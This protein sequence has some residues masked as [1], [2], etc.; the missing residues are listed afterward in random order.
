M[1]RNG[2]RLIRAALLAVVVAVF[3]H[4]RAD[5]DLWGHVRFGQDTVAA[6]AV[7]TV[8]RYSFASD[9]PWINHEWLAEALMY[10]AYAAAAGPGLILLKVSVLLLM[11]WAAASPWPKE[12][13]PKYRDLMV[14]LVV[15]GTLPQANHIRPQLFS[16]ILFA[17]L[18]KILVRGADTA[19]EQI[20]RGVAVTLLMV[21]WANLHGGWI[22]GLG[23]LGLWSAVGVSFNGPRHGRA[24][25]V[26]T[27]AAAALATVANPYG[28]HLWQFLWQTVGF[29]RD[30]ITD[31]QPIYALGGAYLGVWLIVAGVA[32]VAVHRSLGLGAA[33]PRSM[34]VVLMLGVASFRVNRLLAFFALAVTMLL[35]QELVQA[36]SDTEDS[37]PALAA[38]GESPPAF[39]APS[40]AAAIGAAVIGSLVLIGALAF[41][42]DNA[43]CVRME[44]RLFPEPEASLVIANRAVRGRMLTWFDWGEYAIWHFSPAVSVSLDGRRETV[45]SDDT[46]NKQFRFYFHP[47]ERQAILDEIKPD[48]IWLPAHLEVR[49]ALESDGWTPLFSGDRSVLLGRHPSDGEPI[50]QVPTGRRCFPGP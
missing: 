14:G 32:I 48:Y 20:G 5:P 25:L 33:D 9:R 6:R 42:Y 2:R 37:A 7:Q 21:A 36:L 43:S 49:S 11:L 22:V 19:R 24:A 50:A 46:V 17:V 10:L 39:G 3:S 30:Q 16:L 44:S 8:D 23:T 13:P 15:I 31:W 34:A 41:S 4:S 18:L 45:Y 29:G 28:W 47:N 40:A 27:T 35:A 26:C 38:R 12:L 1:V